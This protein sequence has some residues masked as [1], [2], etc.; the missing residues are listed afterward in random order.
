MTA[1]VVQFEKTCPRCGELKPITEF[2]R[3]RSRPDGRGSY[4]R[5]CHRG[6]YAEY[7]RSPRGREAARTAHLR[8]LAKKK[9]EFEAAVAELSVEDRARLGL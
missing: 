9:A 4:C 8:S 7:R 6:V 2:A 5:P 3:N 1:N